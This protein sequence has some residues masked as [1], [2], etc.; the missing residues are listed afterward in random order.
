[1]SERKIAED[2]TA[3][4]RIVVLHHWFRSHQLTSCS[5][6]ASEEPYLKTPFP[7][8]P[9]TVTCVTRFPKRASDDGIMTENRITAA[10]E[11]IRLL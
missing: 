11:E 4:S 3:Q 10:H 8:G 9:H 2:R 6:D 1:M 5:L 7:L